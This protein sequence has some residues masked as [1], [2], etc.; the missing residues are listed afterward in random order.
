MFNLNMDI[1]PDKVDEPAAISERKEKEGTIIP[2]TETDLIK[3]DFVEL[4]EKPDI[5]NGT[6]ESRP[7][8]YLNAISYRLDIQLRL[9]VF[10]MR[11]E[12]ITADRE[13]RLLTDRT[14]NSEIKYQLSN[15]G[16]TNCEFTEQAV[17]RLLD[18]NQYNPAHEVMNRCY[19]GYKQRHNGESVIDKFLSYFTF[20][21]DADLSRT[22]FKKWLVGAVE[23]LYNNR[24]QNM[25]LILHGGQGTGKSFLARWLC[26]ESSYFKSFRIRNAVSKYDLLALSE[27]MIV[28][29]SEFRVNDKNYDDIKDYITAETIKTDRK[30]E[31]YAEEYRSY[32]SIIGTTNSPDFIQCDY[33]RRFW[34][35]TV[36]HIDR[37]YATDIDIDSL[38]GN[39][40]AL[41]RS[42]YDSDLTEDEASRLK[43]IQENYTN[44]EHTFIQEIIEA[45]FDIDL[46]TKEYGMNLSE[47]SEVIHLQRPQARIS[48]TDLNRELSEMGLEK[49]QHRW[50]GSKTPSRK[51]AGI[52]KKCSTE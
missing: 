36:T 51:Y 14:L 9:N 4:V 13:K 41:Y 50:N 28:E 24:K 32:A 43:S 20:S 5:P 35:L 6:K 40:Y 52:R 33:D 7:A 49:I 30:Y 38:W 8:D 42:G 16:Y 10:G 3:T 48:P 29:L 21:G 44:P 2:S 34:V 18:S 47:I 26:P 19:I 17:S 15:I 23:K 45:L 31:R 22:L 11:P 27:N 46:T 12:I 37:A 39:A 1:F 25:A